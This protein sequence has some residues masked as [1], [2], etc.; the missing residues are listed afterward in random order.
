MGELRNY[1]PQFQDLVNSATDFSWL[2]PG[3][4]VLLKIALNSGNPYPMTTDP[5]LV[6][7]MVAL[8]S[9]K[10]ASTI[11]AGDQSGAEHV[12]WTADSKKGVPAASSA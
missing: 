6:R 2:K 7:C 4:T 3:D 11:L 10:G 8:L 12:V 1:Y 9:E 5:W